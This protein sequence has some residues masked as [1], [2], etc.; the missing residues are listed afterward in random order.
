MSDTPAL[1]RLTTAEVAMLSTLDDRWRNVDQLHPPT[2]W[3]ESIPETVKGR[4]AV[5][6]RLT[7][8]R[9]VDVER[10]RPTRANPYPFRWRLNERGAHALRAGR[11]AYDI[12]HGRA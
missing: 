8:L 1:P 2:V 12:R 10:S 11:I 5:V 4:S 6:Q 7:R 9:L 3:P